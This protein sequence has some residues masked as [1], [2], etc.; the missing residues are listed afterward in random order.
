MVV[1]SR[2]D[3]MDSASP[4]TSPAGQIPATLIRQ[5]IRHLDFRHVLKVRGISK[6]WRDAV[7]VV[8]PLRFPAAYH[9][10]VELVQQILV[11]MSPVDF[12]NARRTCMA[13]YIS[14]LNVP[15]LRKH[16]ETMGFSKTD[17]GIVESKNPTYLSMRLSRECSLGADGSGR[18]GLRNVAVFDLSEM[19]TATTSHF[20][21]ST[22]NSH[23]LLCDGCVVH[24]YRLQSK[25]QELVEFVAT[26]I[27]P[28]RVIAVSM[29]TRS[30]RYSVAVLLVNYSDCL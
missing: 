29:D 8:R 23:V 3:T 22:C 17:P 10:P 6:A 27:C 15:V 2:I 11:L 18:C 13:W 25:G 28:R 9:L 26:I 7:Q 19:A 21:V 16:L 14:S 5:T 20:T 24:A 1:R 4:C 12:N 30:G